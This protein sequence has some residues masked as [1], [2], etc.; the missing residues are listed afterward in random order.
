MIPPYWK[1]ATK[2]LSKTDTILKDLIDAKSHLD[3][4][5]KTD[6]FI[7]L[8]RAIVGQQI[9][10]KAAETIWGRIVSVAGS[11]KPSVISKITE[12]KLK[13]AGLSSRKIEYLKD[14][15]QKFESNQFDFKSWEKWE[16]AEI[17]KQLISVKG[18]GVWTAEMFLIFYM[19]RPNV[20]PTA[21][22]GLQRAI[23]IHYKDRDPITV[24]EMEAIG[25]KWAPWRTVA[26]W[27]LWRSIDPIP[28]EY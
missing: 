24:Q 18:I 17:I 16:D 7:T 1:K 10:V 11:P 14:L 5:L 25:H 22:I 23:S 27:Y 3:I 4:K 21:D 6:P 8:A 19:G 20:F 2:S 9:S 12:G 15:G 26:T 28:V 13:K